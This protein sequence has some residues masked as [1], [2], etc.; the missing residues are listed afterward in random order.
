VVTEIVVFGRQ[1]DLSGVRITPL[2]VV[3][4]GASAGAGLLGAL[5][6]LIAPTAGFIQLATSRRM[7]E[8]ARP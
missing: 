7:G 8:T 3:A 4:A 5:W 2:V 6:M 1:F